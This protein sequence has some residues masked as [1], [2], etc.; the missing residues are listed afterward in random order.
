MKHV[1]VFAG[2]T[3]GRKI[4]EYLADSGIFVT[5]C[6]ATE[7]GEITMPQRPEITTHTGRLDS[8]QMAS[9]MQDSE[10]VID[11]THPYAVIVSDYIKKACEATG[12]EYIRL[13]RP[14]I[15]TSDAIMVKDAKAA[16]QFLS[17][18][19]GNV[20]L[21]TGTK[22]LDFFTGLANYQERLF[23]RV[24]PSVEAL[25]TCRELGFKASHLIC[26]QGP[27][28]F[29]LNVAM[30]RQINAKYLVTKESG[31]A[32][33]FE[34]KI[35]AAKAAGVTV[36]LIGR[37]HENDGFTF[38]GL[39]KVLEQRLNL[40]KKKTNSH[41]PLFV[42]IK[43]KKAVI[44]GAGKI[45]ARR[46]ISLL[47]FGADVFVVAPDLC[48]EIEKLADDEKIKIAC[49]EYT[50]SDLDGAVLA[51][52][53]TNDR[54]VNKAVTENAKEQR[55]PISVADRREESSFYFPAIFEGGGVVGGLI[56]SGG[57][58]HSKVREKA[59]EIRM[60][61]DDSH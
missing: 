8:A 50:K 59:T 43:D 37:P 54:A 10:L 47:K 44:V 26:M 45:A 9:F 1:L 48:E 12:K 39:K 35:S 32:G 2:T 49:R 11:A 36:I 60:L 58:N 19:D 34:E 7:Y 52:A 30:L 6:V 46:A 15:G 38:E 31:Q 29:E 40:D 17:G 41:F 5:A 33:G 24:L 21:T 61:L 22:E 20:L 27:F 18:T 51:V 55:I 14:Q 23:A 28:S 4:S 56:S 57:E 3:E 13:I 16:A 25:T 42:D 53:A